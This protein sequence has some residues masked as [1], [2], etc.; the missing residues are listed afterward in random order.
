M[1]S[2]ISPLY[3]HLARQ[4]SNKIFKLARA[5]P[6][7]LLVGADRGFLAAR[8]RPRTVQKHRSYGDLWHAHI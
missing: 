3:S 5:E 6:Q 4:R 2:R 1:V 7:R 8:I